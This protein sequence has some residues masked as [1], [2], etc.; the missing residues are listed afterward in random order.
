MIHN[1]ITNRQLQKTDNKNLNKWN[2][3][4]DESSC[5][6]DW[7]RH[8]INP[9]WKDNKGKIDSIAEQVSTRR[10]A[11]WSEGTFHRDQRF[12]FPEPQ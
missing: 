6:D 1:W 8:K 5:Q 10:E 11:P 12:C 3:S 4:Q 9:L 2:D 7:L